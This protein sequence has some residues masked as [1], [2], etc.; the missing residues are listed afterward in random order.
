MKA[1]R[2]AVC[3]ITILLL[4]FPIAWPGSAQESAPPRDVGQD[5]Q[6]DPE[7][8]VPAG[9]TI[10]VILTTFLNTKSSQVGD[11]FYADTV[12]PI[13][14]QQ[15][16]AIPRGS[17]IKGTV[18]EVVRPGRIKGKG[19]L[20][21]RFDNILLPN[22]VNRDLIAAPRGLHG[23]GD[24]KLDRKTETVEQS[25]TKGQDAGTVAGP[26]GEGAIIGAI[27]N[28]GTG[29]GVGAGVGAAVGLATVLVTR[30]R[31]LI[32]QPGTQF[33]L[34]L[35]QPLKFAYGELQF[36]NSQL[37]SGRHTIAPRAPAGNHSGTRGLFP[38]RRRWPM[39]F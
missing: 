29:A 3:A 21:I 17:T 10:P 2:S 13:W 4:G 15:R 33:D 7:L 36:S 5:S 27:S 28:G 24:E 20:A 9:I 6:G 16:L 31:D 39:P 26:A 30:G 25:G 1:N 11:N 19:R 34:E 14:I 18:T 35:K 22:G 32:L 37:N 38:A 12:Y 8:T 23:P